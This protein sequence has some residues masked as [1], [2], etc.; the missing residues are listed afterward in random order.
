MKAKTVPNKIK[1]TVD[2]TKHGVFAQNFSF[3][4]KFLLVLIKSL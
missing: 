4:P 3:L 1:I 2:A